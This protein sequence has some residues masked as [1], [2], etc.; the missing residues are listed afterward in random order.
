MGEMGATPIWLAIILVQAN[1]HSLA[2]A[3]LHLGS[4][5]SHK[6]FIIIYL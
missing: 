2:S 1:A 4:T 3:M 6:L 5:V